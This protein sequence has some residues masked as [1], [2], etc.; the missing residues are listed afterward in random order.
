MIEE[1]GQHPL[2]NSRPAG[3]RAGYY[4]RGDPADETLE[5]ARYADT[6]VSFVG[7]VVYRR[8][9][10]SMALLQWTDSV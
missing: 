4:G 3:R 10:C 1:T 5:N 8:A 9:P 6:L 7:A 2:G